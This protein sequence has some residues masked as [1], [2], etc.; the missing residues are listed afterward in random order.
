VKWKNH[1][2]RRLDGKVGLR[3]V[4]VLWEDALASALDWTEDPD[5]DPMPTY[6]LGYIIKETDK[7]LTL[8]QMI[9][10]HHVGHVVTIP[11]SCIIERTEL[12]WQI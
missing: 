6:T 9:N 4:E 5:V 3:I 12:T 11:K 2:Q 8:A 7:N 1:V 10:L